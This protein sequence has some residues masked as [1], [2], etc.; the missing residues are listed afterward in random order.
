MPGRY[1]SHPGARRSP[2]YSP[3]KLAIK[4]TIKKHLEKFAYFGGKE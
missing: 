4:N 3:L 1:K 2:I